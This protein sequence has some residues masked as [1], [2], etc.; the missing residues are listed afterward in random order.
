MRLLT[1]N[2]LKSNVKG[3]TDGYPLDIEAVT[4]TEDASPVDRQVVEKFLTKIRYDA[5][6]QATQQLAGS[7]EKMPELPSS[8]PEGGLDDA[9]IA[10]LH[11]CLFDVHL[12]E[13][14]LI[15]PATGRKFPVKDGIPNMILH[16]DEI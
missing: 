7:T 2:Y 10:Q 15:C 6:Y 9:L 16:E 1:H 14:F 4:V 3:T 13:G 12:I 8:L 11:F 5:L